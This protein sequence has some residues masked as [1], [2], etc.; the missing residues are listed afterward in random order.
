MRYKIT[1]EYDGTPFSGWQRQ[2][3]AP[4][5]Q[6][7]IEEALKRLTQEDITLFV[8]GR[9]DAGVHAL[10]QICHFDIKKA[11]EPFRLRAALNAHLRPYPIRILEAEQVDNEFHARFSANS[12]TYLYQILQRSAPP[13][14]DVNRVWH[15]S[16]PLDIDSMKKASD[17]LIGHHDFTSFRSSHCQAKS[18]IRTLSSI[19]IWQEDNYLLTQIHAPSFLHHQVRNIMGTLA[20]VGLGKRPIDWVADVLIAQNRCLAGATAPANGLYLM[21]VGYD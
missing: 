11:F 21:E 18:P 15:I 1:V 16:Q 5:V 2:L 12:R 19:D 13:A 17:H 10:A 6:A 8:A 7:T 3:D 14:L 9:T 20:Q 4:S